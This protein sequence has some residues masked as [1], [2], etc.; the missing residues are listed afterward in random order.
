MTSRSG[1][2]GRERRRRRRRRRRKKKK[3]KKKKKKEVHPC[4][5]HL[6]NTMLYHQ[7]TPHLP[8]L[9]R[10]VGNPS[11]AGSRVLSLRQ[12]GPLRRRSAAFASADDALKETRLEDWKETQE[13]RKRRR[14]AGKKE[15]GKGRERSGRRGGGTKEPAEASKAAWTRVKKKHEQVK[16]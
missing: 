3:K 4:S 5:L 14:E 6:A 9:S 13:R 8:T 11:Q 10:S 1:G 12:V 7:I 15:G 16:S 2:R